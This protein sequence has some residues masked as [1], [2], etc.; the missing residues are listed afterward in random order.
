[1]VLLAVSRKD[2]IIRL[3]KVDG[4]CCARSGI[5]RSFPR[6]IANGADGMVG[7]IN[8]IDGDAVYEE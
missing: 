5:C 3:G 8:R 4:V 2:E 1:M 6:A 7:C